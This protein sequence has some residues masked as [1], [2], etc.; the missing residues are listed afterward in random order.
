MARPTK[1][2]P[3]MQHAL[4]EYVGL[5]MTYEQSCDLAG[6][7]YSN[8][9]RWMIR[10]APFRAAIKEA[11]VKGMYVCLQSIRAAHQDPSHWQAAMTWL[12]RR[13]PDQWGKRERQDVN[14]TGSMDVRQVV[15][16]VQAAIDATVTDADTRRRLAEQLMA[17]E[18]AEEE[19]AQ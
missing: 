15:R 3:N 6:I 7:D 8:F 1:Y 19:D 5:G 14:I 17:L 2:T 12:E 9:K 10:F 13:F 11:D 18:P 16:G 4:C